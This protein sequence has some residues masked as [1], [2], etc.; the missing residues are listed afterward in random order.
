MMNKK[1]ILGLALILTL[2]SCNPLVPNDETSSNGFDL[3]NST[4]EDS[5]S[6]SSN[7]NSSESGSGD[8]SKP[9][10]KKYQ[11]FFY[12]DKTE[13][14]HTSVNEGGSVSYTG[15][16]PTKNNTST[17]KYT[18]FG[19]SEDSEA[20]YT[21]ALPNNKLP[22]ITKDT[23]FFAIFKEEPIISNSYTATFYSNIGEVY[24]TVTKTKGQKILKSDLNR[25][26]DP[27]PNYS[28]EGKVITFSNAW[29]KIVNGVV[30]DKHYRFDSYGGYL[31]MSD[32][33]TQADINFVAN[34]YSNF[35][36]Y[37]CNFCS[38]DGTPLFSFDL[39]HGRTPSESKQFITDSLATVN[40]V[41]FEPDYC[42][43]GKKYSFVGWSTTKGDSVSNAKSINNLPAVYKKQSYY[44]IVNLNSSEPVFL[45]ITGEENYGHYKVLSFEEALNDNYIIVEGTEL[46][47]FY[48]NKV[49]TNN[50]YNVDKVPYN[51]FISDN[52][53]KTLGTNSLT[54]IS[55]GSIK[56]LSIS[57]VETIKEKAFEL[58]N[59]DSD[60]AVDIDGKNVTTLEKNAFYKA[61]KIRRVSLPKISVIPENCFKDSSI[62]EPVLNSDN[63]TKISKGAFSNCKKI[64]KID[65]GKNVS[66]IEY[67][68][69]GNDASLSPFSNDTYNSNY[70]EELTVNSANQTYRS[71]NNAIIRKSDNALIFATNGTT[72][73]PN[74]V[75]KIAKGAF[76]GLN[77][78][79]ATLT[80]PSTVESI[81]NGAFYK[82]PVE[83]IVYQGTKAEFKKLC[84]AS[85]YNLAL[86]YQ[87]KLKFD[88]TDVTNQ[89]FR[90]V[91]P[92]V[93]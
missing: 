50:L 66:N 92:S 81:A 44:A 77:M 63:L 56:S 29:N 53:I 38:Y 33:E 2:A 70:M 36:K 90:D 37:N 64:T 32:D 75:K 25:S 46:T 60:I 93:D 10:Q 42:A 21:S 4:S 35:I 7:N 31:D 34:Y 73:I 43:D 91:F 47:R 19:W 20:N 41:Y 65:I 72:T 14:Y 45:E 51:L 40:K 8:S 5:G 13:L 68:S 58:F 3:T 84:T 85:F 62:Y 28:E 26:D 54:N 80:I 24:A 82:S 59:S 83:K 16:P 30:E 18:F 69:A 6:G 27:V 48:E 39:D 15:N 89:A 79:D 87:L 55:T 23:Y 12:N 1:G 17:T 11:V 22:K 76:V 71:E 61:G 74:S 49:M 78:G 57:S 52:R 86:N 67:Q 88:F 9:T